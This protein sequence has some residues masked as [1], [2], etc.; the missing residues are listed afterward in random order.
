MGFNFEL[1]DDQIIKYTKWCDE[2]IKDVKPDML[3]IRETFV[4]IPCTAGLGV[5][6]VCGQHQLDLTEYDKLNNNK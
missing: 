6:V 4:F 3:G 5:K 2:V 1:S